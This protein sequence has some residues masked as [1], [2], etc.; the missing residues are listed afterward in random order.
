[1]VG[2]AMPDIF[3]FFYLAAGA[4]GAG[5]GF[6]LGVILLAC[7]FSPWIALACVPA[8]ATVLALLAWWHC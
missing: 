5:A 8:G 4:V 6:V 3:V 1:M 7:G 2:G